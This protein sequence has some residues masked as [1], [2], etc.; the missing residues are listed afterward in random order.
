MKNNLK[1]LIEDVYKLIDSGCVPNETNL[2]LLGEHIKQAVIKQL[3]PDNR[4]IKNTLRM[5]NLGKK[6]R[7]LWYELNSTEREI[8]EPNTRLKFLFGDI[9]EGLLLYL[10]KEADYE[11]TNEQDKV[12][13]D[14]I[15]GHI[16][17][18]INGVMVDVKSASSFSFKKFKEGT[19]AMDDPFGYIAQISGYA[20]AEKCKEAGFLVMDKQLGHITY[21]EVQDK[22]DVPARIKNI[23]KVIAQ[24]EPPVKKCYDPIADGKSGNKKLAVGCSYCPYK[25]TCWADANDGQGIRTFLYSTGPRFLAHV[26]REP[27]V[28]EIS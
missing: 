8:L 26:E 28:Y 4:Q 17:C 16:D 2:E 27:D 3:H 14:G 9:I 12:E 1:N 25:H 20:Y 15:V 5:S 24:P 11:V 22:I 7:Q 18:K 23:K 6:D 10:V 19:L 21:M 13:V